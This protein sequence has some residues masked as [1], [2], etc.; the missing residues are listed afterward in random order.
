MEWQRVSSDIRWRTGLPF[1][2]G[3]GSS[4]PAGSFQG[5]VVPVGVIASLQPPSAGHPFGEYYVLRLSSAGRRRR[6]HGQPLKKKKEVTWSELATT[7]LT[8][9]RNKNRAVRNAGHH[10]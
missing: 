7:L 1:V 2:Q 8:M 5:Q 9:T 4:H 6:L 3:Q 10:P